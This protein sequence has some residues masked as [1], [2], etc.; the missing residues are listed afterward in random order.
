M[1]TPKKFNSTAVQTLENVVHEGK[2]DGLI[3]CKIQRDRCWSTLFGSISATK[4][5]S[6]LGRI[7]KKYEKLVQNVS[8]V[9]WLL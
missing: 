8:F 1:P 5:R 4:F 3:P 9:F 6:M 2:V 7:R